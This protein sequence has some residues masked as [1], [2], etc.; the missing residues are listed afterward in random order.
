MLVNYSLILYHGSS[1]LMAIKE[2]EEK[3]GHAVHAR[4]DSEVAGVGLTFPPERERRSP[5]SPSKSSEFDGS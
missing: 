5:S 1:N 2:G 3:F 4:L